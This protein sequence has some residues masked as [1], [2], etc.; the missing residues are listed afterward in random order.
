MT[1]SPHVPFSVAGGLLSAEVFGVGLLVTVLLAD[2]D[3][4]AVPAP[5]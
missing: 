2:V 5:S 4:D 1:P 3:V